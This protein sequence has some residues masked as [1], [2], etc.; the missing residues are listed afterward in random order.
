MMARGLFRYGM[1]AAVAGAGVVAAGGSFTTGGGYNGVVGALEADGT[2]SDE[3]PGPWA[4]GPYV[5]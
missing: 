4:Y 3:L 1:T 2:L 5:P